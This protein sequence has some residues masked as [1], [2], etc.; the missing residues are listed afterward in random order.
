MSLSQDPDLTD[1]IQETMIGKMLIKSILMKRNFYLTAAVVSALVLFSCTREE[2]PSTENGIVPDQEEVNGQDPEG[3]PEENPAVPSE[4]N[5]VF[6]ASKENI[7]DAKSEQDLKS[8][9]AE[10]GA[11][12]WT[13]GD[14]ITILWD[15]GR[16]TA[17]TTDNGAE[18]SFSATVDE[19]AAGGTYYSV[20]PSSV[21]TE[22]TAT[23]ELSVTIPSLQDGTFSS[24]NINVAKTTSNTFAF[25]AVG[26]I[27]QF[28]VSDENV[29][30]M[31]IYSYDQTPL[32]GTCSVNVSEE[33]PTISSYSAT[34][35]DI[36]VSINGAGTYYAVLLPGTH[37]EGLL[38]APETA[39]EYKRAA[40]A[41]KSWTATRRYITDFG[42]I[43]QNV[44]D[45]YVSNSGIG[46]GLKAAEPMSPSDF[47]ALLEQPMDSD[48]Q[49]DEVAIRRFRLLYG[50]TIHILDNIAIA[51]TKVEYT[52][53]INRPCVYTIAGATGETQISASGTNRLFRFSNNTEVT[54]KDITLTGGSA[55][56][57]GA[58][59]IDNG[60][61]G[62]A[63][64]ICN[65][66][67]FDSNSATNGNGGAVCLTGRAQQASFI[68]T[69]CTFTGN[70]ASSRGG[71]FYQSAGNDSQAENSSTSFTDCVF[72]GNTAATNAG[73]AQIYRGTATFTGNNVFTSNTSATGG[74]FHVNGVGVL[75]MTGGVFGVDDD[76]SFEK[77]NMATG[78]G[79]GGGV[80]YQEKGTVSFT[81]T[82]FQYNKSNKNGGLVSLT[83]ASTR[84]SMTNCT[85]SHNSAAANGGVAYLT[86]NA[87]LTLTS[88]V[89][90]FNKAASGGIAQIYKGE[91]IVDGTST[92]NAN[93]V[94]G[95]GGV[96]YL[97]SASASL[98]MTGASILDNVAKDGSTSAAEATE[99]GAGICAVSSS[100]VTLN[101][102][103][104][105]N[106]RAGAA[107]N[108]DA[109]E[110]GGALCIK[111]ATITATLCNFHGNKANRGSVLKMIDGGGLF[112][113]DRCS[114]HGNKQY[115]R[116]AFLLLVNNVA[117]FNQCSFF[118]QELR[119]TSSVYGEQ[120]H[121][122]KTTAVCLNNCSINS[123]KT[124]YSKS[125]ATINSD[126]HV[127]LANSTVIGTSASSGYGV[128]RTG[129]SSSKLSVVNSVVVNRNTSN[130]SIA[131][132]T[133]AGILCG[134]HNALGVVNTNFSGSDNKTGVEA[135]SYTWSAYS[136]ED[137]SLDLWKNWFTCSQLTGFNNAT[138]ADVVAAFTGF[139]ID[140]SGWGGVLG[141]MTHVGN[142]FKTWLDG[143]SPA[144]YT[145][146]QHGAARSASFWPGSYQN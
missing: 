18:A 145:V 56:Q 63:K 105:Y 50:N 8:S 127:L 53:A 144:A 15:G 64:V 80:L 60:S 23:D 87:T 137:N 85:F 138:S 117:M 11:V 83:G 78:T 16:T 98:D 141:S 133:A 110:Y 38:F 114:F 36:E 113:A 115:S 129:Q 58:I 12:T 17:V 43:D 29:T 40:Y 30:K 46:K 35:S 100:T 9:L 5:I 42:D 124:S 90:K 13:S 73:V 70:T 119:G 49:D 140:A 51:E 22:M 118:G 3:Q 44:R 116:G 47:T 37:A 146:N 7:G 59:E 132:Y 139:N 92:Y 39:T 130:A 33:V 96:F 136:G 71:V 61:A 34:S 82:K 81:G 48:A 20:Y 88:C 21:S 27:V 24:A 2:L 68:A 28:T 62:T 45:I 99:T 77:A 131:S 97:N 112:K 72:D 74:V 10:G 142:A 55:A 89:G 32:A 101:S 4:G 135:S 94:T 126:A 108:T 102:C 76:S 19:E 111:G 79:N 66:V 95:A 109:K 143:F 67:T 123:T 69:G 104:F 121:C 128:I 86:N 1:T 41:Y 84:C 103:Y 52:G 134:D 107:D 57:G 122:G 6:K 106:N 91:V 75:N 125:V 31:R 26:N 14:A 25:K 65:N 93:V 120:I 54:F